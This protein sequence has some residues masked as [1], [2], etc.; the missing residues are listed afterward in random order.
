MALLILFAFLAGVAT[1][2]APCILPILP[3]VLS[4]GVTGGKRRPLGIVAGLVVSFT[5]FTLTLS[6]LV[7]H[8]GISP[9]LLR[10]AAILLLLSFGIVLLVPKLLTAFEV[11]LSSRISAGRSGSERTDFWGGVLIGVS[12][13][14]VWTPCVGPIVASVISLA[15]T[16]S[17]TITSV[18]ITAA[19]ALGTSLPLLVIMYGGKNILSRVKALGKYTVRVQQGF[20]VVMIATALAMLTGFDRTIQTVLLAKLPDTISA[21]ITQQLEQGAIVQSQLHKLK[22][23]SGDSLS[24]SAQIIGGASAGL[25]ILG[26]A[27]N[28]TGISHWLN[29]DPLTVTQLKGKVVLI[30]FWTYSCINCIRTLPHVTSWYDTYKSQG[31][32]VVGVHAPEFAFEKDTTNVANAI[33][34]YNIHYPVAQ[35][36]D[37]ATW[38][39]YGNQY[40]PAEYLI[41]ANGNIRATHFGEGNYDETEANI[42]ALLKEAAMTTTLPTMTETGV[43][44]TPHEKQSPET[45]LGTD[46]QANFLPN[47]DP[48]KLATNEWTVKGEWITAGQYITSGKVGDSLSYKFT[49]Q[50]AYLVLNPPNGVSASVQVLIDGK[51]AGNLGGADVNAGVIMVNTSRLYH[52]A[53]VPAGKDY[54]L[55]LVFQTPGVKAFSFT[56]G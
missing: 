30:D 29:S 31:L 9:D 1:I 48:E 55:T 16:S 14:L 15:A 25:P 5:F 52:L 13:G 2:F 17:V 8:L 21:G 6:Y 41:D 28:F 10:T 34:Q 39:A 49:G 33:K 37:L 46:R 4:A 43:D 3:V 54:L 26:T 32:V 19:Y 20:G 36:N 35:D 38:S 56:F 50:D 47:T 40:W 44:T 53:H 24:K 18:L 7:K 22:G 23:E 42:R 27:P 51:P 11:M 12:L 45:Y